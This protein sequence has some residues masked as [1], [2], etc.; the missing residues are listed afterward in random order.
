[1]QISSKRYRR[2]RFIDLVSTVLSIKT[3]TSKYSPFEIAVGYKDLCD[4]LKY[5]IIA[6][7]LYFYTKYIYR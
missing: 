2:G 4:A 3:A 5:Y 1:M 6:S 7:E